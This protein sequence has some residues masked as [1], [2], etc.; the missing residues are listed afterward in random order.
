MANILD[1]V[2][3]ARRW[4]N[5]ELMVRQVLQ[6]ASTGG[7]TARLLRLT[8][9]RIESCT[10]CMRCAMTGKSCRLQ[11]DMAWLIDAVQAADALVLAAPPTF[12][13][14]QP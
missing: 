3:Y 10:G 12:S 4:G 2:G 6:G 11:D 9:L 5:S 7:S 13:V 1:I 8:A 14:P